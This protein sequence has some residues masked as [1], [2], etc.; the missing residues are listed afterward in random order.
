MDRQN[1]VGPQFTHDCT[2]CV[3]LGRYS[4]PPGQLLFTL[5]NEF[6]LYFCKASNRCLD[7]VVARFGNEGSEYASGHSSFYPKP[8]GMDLH[9]P[10][11]IAVERANARQIL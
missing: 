11:A 8:V 4:R 5:K 3:F 9:N 1:E 6:D 10:L 7:T 2:A